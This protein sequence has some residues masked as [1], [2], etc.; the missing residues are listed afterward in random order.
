MDLIELKRKLDECDIP[1]WDTIN[2]YSLWL[3]FSKIQNE[4]DELVASLGKLT[5]QAKFGRR[6]YKIPAAFKKNQEEWNGMPSAKKDVFNMKARQLRQ[7]MNT[8]DV[9]EEFMVTNP[10]YAKECRRMKVFITEKICSLLDG[11][12]KTSQ[13]TTT[14]YQSGT[15]ICLDGLYERTFPI[16]ELMYNSIYGKRMDKSMDLYAI[17]RSSITVELQSLERAM[18]FFDLHVSEYYVKTYPVPKVWLELGERKHH[19]GV[20][21]CIGYVLKHEGSSIFV[22]CPSDLSLNAWYY[23][24]N[25]AGCSPNPFSWHVGDIQNVMVSVSKTKFSMRVIFNGLT[26]YIKNGKPVYLAAKST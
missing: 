18:S 1:G 2:G 22:V 8:P 9:K 5:M 3:K 24:S 13:A 12:P 17:T 25:E 14:W 21:T 4:D 10:K 15:S 11:K 16:G 20:K 19:D 7:T 6:I 23:N 26:F